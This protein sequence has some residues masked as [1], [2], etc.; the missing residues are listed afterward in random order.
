MQVAGQQHVE[1]GHADRA[2]QVGRPGAHGDG[3]Q[4]RVAQH[5]PQSLA[6]SP[7]PG[8]GQVCGWGRA[9]RA[10]MAVTQAADHRKLSASASTAYGAVRAWIRAGHRRAGDLGDRLAGLQ[11]A[12]PSTR[13]LTADELGQVGLVGDVEED[14]G[15]PGDQGDQVKLADGQDPEEPGQRDRA[16]GG[17][18]DQVVDDQDGPEPHPLDPGAGRQPD[19]Q[20]GRGLEARTAGR[21]PASSRARPGS[22]PAAGPAG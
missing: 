10:W 13:L 22:R 14:R 18:A 2:E 21:L 1:H 5:E 3:A 9:G 8:S 16:Q 7:G 20:E 15:H 4:Q 6:R 19:E 12:L 11:L 17:R